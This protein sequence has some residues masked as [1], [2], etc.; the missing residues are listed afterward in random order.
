MYFTSEHVSGYEVIKGNLAADYHYTGVALRTEQVYTAEKAGYVNY[1]AAEGEKVSVLSTVYTIDESGRMSE[2]LNESAG[3]LS[4]DE[5]D[6]SE[7]RA[8]I[9]SYLGNYSDM[10]FRE[11]YDFKTNVDSAI[12][13]LV[14]QNLIDQLDS[15]S[16][17]AGTLFT[18][19]NAETAG[20]VE[21]YIDGLESATSDNIDPSWFDEENYEWQDL[22]TASLVS[23]GDPVYKLVTEEDWRLSSRWMKIWK[24][25]F[26]MRWNRIRLRLRTAP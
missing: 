20:V 1:Y 3:D 25:I 21:Y 9:S 23:A 17:D 15:A 18:R 19:Y 7:I 14:N 12:L 2:L 5:E 8:D 6:Y 4:L 10:D 11:V 26:W 24:I 13:D 22:R 16:E